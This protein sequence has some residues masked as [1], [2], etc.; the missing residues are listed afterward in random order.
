M[1]TEKKFILVCV[2]FSVKSCFL[3]FNLGGWFEAWSEG[4]FLPPRRIYLLLPG[5]WNHYSLGPLWNKF[6][7]YGISDREISVNLRSEAV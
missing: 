2:C 3:E 6:S 7:A 5:A 1:Y 4:K